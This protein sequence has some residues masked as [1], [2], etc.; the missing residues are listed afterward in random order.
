M[1]V[2]TVIG[3]GWKAEVYEHIHLSEVTVYGNE[4]IAGNFM[5]SMAENLNPAF[6]LLKSIPFK[7]TL[8]AIA[9]KEEVKKD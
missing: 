4:N 7:K 9:G 1:V 6:E 8:N 3:N 5:A 2:Q